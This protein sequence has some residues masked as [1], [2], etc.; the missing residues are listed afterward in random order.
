MT[1]IAPSN[2]PLCP[3]GRTTDGMEIQ[4]GRRSFRSLERYDFS[5]TRHLA[6]ASLLVEQDL[7][8]KTGIHFSGSCSGSG[9]PSVLEIKHNAP[10]V[11]SHV[12]GLETKLG[13]HL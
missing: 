10:E 12:L 5:S 1:A 13:A 9:I 6:P 8:P 7:F 2:H 4:E 3:R 11:R